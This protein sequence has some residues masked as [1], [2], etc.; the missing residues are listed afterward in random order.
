MVEEVQVIPQCINT[1][2]QVKVL[3]SKLYLSKGTDKAK[4]SQVSIMKYSICGTATFKM[5]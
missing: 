2:L 3:Q 4:F 1:A 5:S